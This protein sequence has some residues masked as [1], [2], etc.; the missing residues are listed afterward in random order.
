MHTN[1][2][3]QSVHQS[4]YIPS[5]ISVAHIDYIMPDVSSVQS[6]ILGLGGNFTLFDTSR[7]KIKG[8]LSGQLDKDGQVVLKGSVT[9]SGSLPMINASATITNSGIYITSKV[10]EF[11][12]ECAAIGDPPV[13]RGLSDFGP[14][15]ISPT[16]GPINV[17]GGSGILTL[18]EFILYTSIGGQ[19]KLTVGNTFTAETKCNFDF[20]GA[21]YEILFYDFDLPSSWVTLIINYI[22]QNAATIFEDIFSDPD[23][24]LNFIYEGIIQGVENVAKILKD[25]FKWENKAIAAGLYINLGYMHQLTW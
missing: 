25:K 18:G 1:N 16:I 5:H 22:K 23:K 8:E 6:D 11:F 3:H 14:T 15:S 12:F 4:A 10:L 20:Q 17:Q 21:S 13:L 7:L 19:I 2:A 24:W 9:N